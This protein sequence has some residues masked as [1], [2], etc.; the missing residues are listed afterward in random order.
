M[1]SERVRHVWWS[2]FFVAF[3]SV[4]G[5]AH[6]ETPAGCSSPAVASARDI[7][8]PLNI[9]I[10]KAELLYYRCSKYDDDVRAVLDD[11][12]QWV[13]LRGAQ[14]NNPA[15]VL[16]IDE[17][18]LS[19][20]TRIQKDDFAYIPNGPCDLSKNG[21]ACGDIAWQQSGQAPAIVPTL[22]LFNAASCKPA[23]SGDGCKK[24]TVFFVTG[25][26]ES[27]E[28][29]GW[30]EKNLANAGYQDWKQ[31]YMR[32]PK[33]SGQ[34]VSGHKTAARTDIEQQGF[35]IIAN[36]GDQNSDLV[37]GH[38]ERVFK[39]PNPFYFIR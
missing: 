21:E 4:A 27:A 7:S 19:N 34:P 32:D 12:R 18:S 25:R 16:D 35:T 20:W 33:A 3:V 26:Y 11:A 23:G 15:I 29:R 2:I 10:V 24:V 1:L 28:A 5:T 8:Q 14:V 31:L 38:A 30:T 17:T 37:G 13:A 39:I 22:E 36:I 9:D 6:A